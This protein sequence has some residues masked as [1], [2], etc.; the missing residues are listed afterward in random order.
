ME[1]AIVAFPQAVQTNEHGRPVVDLDQ[2]QT[3]GSAIETP[4]STNR[5]ETIHAWTCVTS[6][7]MPMV[8]PPDWE[9]VDAESFATQQLGLEGAW[10]KTWRYYKKES[11]F[12]CNK[13][14]AAL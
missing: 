3:L 5:P 7:H 6:G 8:K 13:L 9:I 2:E 10:I 14:H 12:E 1:L 11:Q 4:F